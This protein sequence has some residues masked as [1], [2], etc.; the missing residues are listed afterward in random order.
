MACGLFKAATQR[1]KFFLH[2]VTKAAEPSAKKEVLTQK[3]G[4]FL[5][6]EKKRILELRRSRIERAKRFELR[7]SRVTWF[8]FQLQ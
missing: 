5:Y 4:D 3:R 1:L 6:D 8:V 7:R 2:F